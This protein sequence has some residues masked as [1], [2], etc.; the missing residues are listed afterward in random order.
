MLGERAEAKGRG[1]S[2]KL[3][4]SRAA[5]RDATRLT[6]AC[7]TMPGNA[8]KFTDHG[9]VTLRLLRLEAN[10]ASMLLRFEVR[11]T[12][13]GIPPETCA[14]LFAVFEQADGST[15]RRLWRHRSRLAI[16]RSLAELMGG[17]AGVDSMPGRAVPSGFARLRIGE[18]APKRRW[19][20]ISCPPIWCSCAS[21]L[22][23]TAAG[24]G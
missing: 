24:R 10:D 2:P 5:V 12:G 14:R 18:S 21:T 20:Q 4:G 6:Q 8:V 13:P 16:T 17:S 19:P 7:S 22:A 11:D 15:T 23:A 1:S 9:S 3:N